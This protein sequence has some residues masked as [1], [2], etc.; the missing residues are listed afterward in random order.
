MPTLMDST[1]SLKRSVPL[2]ICFFFNFVLS[3]IYMYIV[4]IYAWV[5]LI[6]SGNIPKFD[7]HQYS[8]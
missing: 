8:H 4:Y 2:G 5:C 1:G 7:Y 3:Y 6:I